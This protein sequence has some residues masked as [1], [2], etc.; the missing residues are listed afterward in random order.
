[1]KAAAIAGVLAVGGALPAVVGA[2][3]TCDAAAPDGV[4]TVH[5]PREYKKFGAG[6]ANEEG[7]TVAYIK[8]CDLACCKKEC[9][10]DPNCFS[11]SH[12]LNYCYLKDRC[13]QASDPWMSAKYVR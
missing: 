3:R 13:M 2:S 6:V 10:A 1:M 8:P 11:F 9:D 12:R 5:A 4:C 7:N